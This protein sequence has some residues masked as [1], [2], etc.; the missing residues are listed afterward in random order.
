M[1]E[2]ANVKEA[3]DA[4]D[5]MESTMMEKRACKLP[6]FAWFCYLMFAWLRKKQKQKNVK[7]GGVKG[8]NF[9]SHRGCKICFFFRQGHLGY[10]FFGTKKRCIFFI[11]G[12]T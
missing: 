10:N 11:F 8:Q 1:N 5:V 9:G 3:R 12:G 4:K 7:H 6:M 2:E